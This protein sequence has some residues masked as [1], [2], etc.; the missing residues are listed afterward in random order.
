MMKTANCPRTQSFTHK[1]KFKTLQF[2][3][4][5]WFLALMLVV[6]AAGCKKESEEPGINGICPEVVATDPSG[7]AV[8]VA[9]IKKVS[10]TFNEAMDTASL[11][12]G[13]FFLKQ[14]SNPVPGTIS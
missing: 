8:N 3:T 11:N 5:K 12:A 14:G 1:Q 4:Y 10:A 6:S 7:G 13:T 9:T 2:S